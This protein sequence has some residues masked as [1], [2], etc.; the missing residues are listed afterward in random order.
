MDRGKGRGERLSQCLHFFWTRGGQLF[1]ILVD[2]FY[3]WT[4][5][6]KTAKLSMGYRRVCLITDKESIIIGYH[7]H[8]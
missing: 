4:L 8:L 6:K 7:D 5:S 1:M 3:G 2:I